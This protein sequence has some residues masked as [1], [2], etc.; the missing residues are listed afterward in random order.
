[1]KAHAAAQQRTAAWS[2]LGSIDGAVASAGIGAAFPTKI[3]V[4]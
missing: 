2:A 1:M 4:V 3:K